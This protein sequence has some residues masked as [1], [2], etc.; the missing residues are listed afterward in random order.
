MKVYQWKKPFGK[1]VHYFL[2][3]TLIAS[4]V[5]G[6]GGGIGA[7]FAKA[8]LWAT[9]FRQENSW[10]LYL[11]PFA[12]V[13]IVWLYH[14]CHEENNRGTN[15]VLEAVSSNQEVTLATGPLIF[16][17]TVLTH[18]VGGSSGREGAALQLGGS[19]GSLSGKLLKLGK[20]DRKIAVMCGMSAVFGA[21]FGTPV[22][23]AMFAVEVASV[24]E[25]YYAGLLPSVFSSFLGANISHALGVPAEAFTILELPKLT[26]VTAAYSVLLGLLCAL[27]SI[28]FCMLL[29]NAHKLYR[30]YIANPYCR[31]LAASALFIALTFIFGTREYH[32]GS[33]QLIEHAMEGHARYEDFLLKALFTAVALGAGFRGG[34]IVPTLCVG[35][36]FG[37]VAGQLAGISPSFSAACGMTALFTGVTNCPLSTMFIA[38]ELFGGEG[39]PFF[40]IVIAVTFTLSGYYGLYSSQRFAC[41]KTEL[42]FVHQEG[43]YQ[44]ETGGDLLTSGRGGAS[45]DKL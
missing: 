11:M 26:P 45:S 1:N 22:A 17:S 8:V 3:W 20:R 37:C 7:C 43:V 34:E 5:G 27:V 40:A 19:L 28:G 42:K 24:G 31:I 16:I 25:I 29:H 2:K 12:G 15:M 38:L 36:T 10:T 18:F 6:V 14:R 13:M 23:A 44:E 39:M 9:S 21:L 30:K 32:G 35:A 4:L 41:S 33:M